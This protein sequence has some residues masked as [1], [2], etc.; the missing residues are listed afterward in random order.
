MTHRPKDVKRAAAILFFL[1]GIS[2]LPAIP[3][4]FAQSSEA[5]VYVAQAILDYEEKKYDAALALLREALAI[6]PD[7]IEALYQMGI[8]LTS[9]EHYAQAIATLSR[10]RQLAPNDAAIAYQLGLAH[11]RIEQYDQAKPLFEDVFAAQPQ[12]E[13]LAYYLG[14]LRYRQKEYAGAV[15]AFRSGMITDPALQQLANFY[16]GLALAI[17]GLPEQAVSSLE[18]ASRIRTV[19]P[20]TGTADRLRDTIVTAQARDR[21][22]HGELRMGAYYDTNVSI[23][24]LGGQAVDP[25]SLNDALLADLRNR[26]SHSPGELLSARGDYAWFRAPGWESTVTASY[27]KTFNNDLPFFNVEN[28]LGGAGLTRSGTVGSMPFQLAGQYTYDYTTLSGSRFMNRHS[29][30]LVATLIENDRH[31]TSLL[32]RLQVKDFSDLFLLGGGTNPA[33]NRDAKNWMVGVIHAFRFNN[34]RHIIRLGYQHD[35]EDAKGLHWSY[36]GHRLLL[37][38]QYTLPWWE[39]RLKY[40]FDFHYRKYQNTNSIFPP[41]DPGTVRQ[42]VY[43]QNHVFRIEQPLPRN[44]VLAYDV[45]ATFSRAN[46]PFMFNYNRLVNTISLAWGF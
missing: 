46:M 37:G 35:M 27:F 24:P 7:H 20:L 32:G 12:T 6:N 5:D 22:L 21:R 8:V 3:S 10:A 23:N 14:F 45:Q 33:E 30:S 40:D 31:L 42:E 1:I 43:E 36:R 9:Q 17:T 18:E 2:L 41:D 29:G 16:S 44:L 38:G 4:A 28:M 15:T 25:N 13:N 34:D 19:S 26:K 11:F 39:M